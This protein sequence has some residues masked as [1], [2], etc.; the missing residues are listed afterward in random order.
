MILQKT[1][2]PKKTVSLNW[3]KTFAKCMCDKRIVS[4]IYNKCLKLHNKKTNTPIEK[5]DKI[6][7][8]ILYVKKIHGWQVKT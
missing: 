6:F 3:K 2:I 5:T 1:L 4:R 7:E 8:H